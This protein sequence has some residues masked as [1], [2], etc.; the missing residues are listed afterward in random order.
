MEKRTTVQIPR[1]LKE[2]LKKA[3]NY[4]RETYEEVLRRLLKKRSI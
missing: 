3:K 1:E 2:E 4:K